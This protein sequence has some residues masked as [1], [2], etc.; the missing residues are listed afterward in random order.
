M[1]HCIKNHQCG[2]TP[3]SNIPL[4][5]ELNGGVPVSE[6]YAGT[7]KPGD[8]IVYSFTTLANMSTH[9]LQ[10]YCLFCSTRRC[11]I[12]LM[13]LL[14]GGMIHKAT[15][16][17][18]PYYEDFEASNG[19]W[20]TG[21][22]MSSWAYGTPAASVINSA[23][24]GTKAWA[25]NLTGNYN[26]SEAS[27]VIAPCFDFTSLAAPQFKMKVWWNSESVLGWCCITKFYRQWHD[28]KTLNCIWRPN[29]WYN[30]NS[31]SGLTTA[32]SS[33][34][35]GWVVEILQAVVVGFG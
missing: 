20:T 3:V 10:H 21:G 9:S 17:S 19:G 11:K 2:S 18:F 30:D 27:Y 13:I 23:S 24:S 26:A 8:T 15:Y 22:S 7:I 35:E 12:Q 4:Q 14:I 16:N 1:N 6:T 28:L 32:I 5:Y 29:N 25:T 33:N 31:I 34:Q